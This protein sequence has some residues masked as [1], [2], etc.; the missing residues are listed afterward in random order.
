[1]GMDWKRISLD[2]MLW[3][4]ALS[5]LLAPV[6]AVGL[7]ARNGVPVIPDAIGCYFLVEY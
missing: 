1:M 4:A 6:Y 5:E 2:Q 3:T 7:A